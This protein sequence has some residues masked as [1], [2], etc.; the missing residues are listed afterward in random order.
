MQKDGNFDAIG[1][2]FEADIYGSSRGLVRLRVLW[3]DLTAAIPELFGGGLIVLD[4]GGGAGHM[5]TELARRGNRVTLA[6]PAEA[7]R[8]RAERVVQQAGVSDRITLSSAPLQ[9]LRESVAGPFDVITCHA[10]LE[11]LADPRSAL[12]ILADLLKPSGHLSIMFYNQNAA[13]L[14]RVLR[15]EFELALAELAGDWRPRGWG[16]G[17][18]PLAE[19]QVRTWLAELHLG[20]RHKAGIRIFHDHLSDEFRSADRLK[21]LIELELASRQRDPFASLAQHI[22]LV[23]T[24]RAEPGMVP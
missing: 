10:V 7:M 24:K 19:E 6:E 18:V 1:D 11:W 2:R 16:D 13:L 21:T 8:S 3:E 14:K 15:G 9:N 5:A 17:C 4:A 20:V 12:V 22:H 23:C